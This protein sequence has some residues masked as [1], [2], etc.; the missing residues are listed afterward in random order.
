MTASTIRDLARQGD[1]A[2]IATLINRSFNPQAITAAVRIQ[3]NYLEILLES[4]P[5][6]PPQSAMVERIRKGL[7]ALGVPIQQVKLH[8]KQ[9]GA[10]FPDW[11]VEIDLEPS[12]A[13]RH[14]RATHSNEPQPTSSQQTSQEFVAKPRSL[15]HPPRNVSHA[16]AVVQLPTSSAQIV[17]LS[18]C[19]SATQPS[20]KLAPRKPRSALLRST[21]RLQLKLGSLVLVDIP[22]KNRRTLAMTVA[23]ITIQAGAIG[24]GLIL[25]GRA[26]YQTA[27]QRPSIIHSTKLPVA[28]FN[29]NKVYQAAI[30]YRHHG[31]PVIDVTFNHNQTFEMIVDTGASGTL[32]TEEMAIALSVQPTGWVQIGVADGRVVQLPTGI[33]NA[34]SVDGATVTNVPVVIA[35]GMPIGLLGH[36]FFDEFDIKISRDTVEFHPRQSK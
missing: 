3:N 17:P 21:T 35:S 9:T 16:P 23:I 29:P 28:S 8:G 36:D 32:I 26:A 2:A 27:N 20:T 4:L 22:V 15:L 24:L 6:A 31:I 14:N 30:K 34:I 19:S 25:W 33:I 5:S 11:S 1:V 7:V 13:L 12:T 10:P 18:P